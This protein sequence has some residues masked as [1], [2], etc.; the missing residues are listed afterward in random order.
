[1]TLRTFLKRADVQ[2]LYRDTFPSMPDQPP[3]PPMAAVSQTTR[4]SAVGTAFDY[5]LRFYVRHLN[6]DAVVCR[7]IAESGVRFAR[8]TIDDKAT[9]ARLESIIRTAKAA[10][11]AIQEHGVIRPE[12]AAAALALAPLDAIFRTKRFSPTWLVEPAAADI[13]DLLTLAELL[14]HQDWLVASRVCR[15]NC[16]FGEASLAIG[17][18]DCDLI[19]DGL[20]VDIKTT[21]EGRMRP[22]D[23]RQILAYWALSTMDPD[24]PAIDTVGVYGARHGV[25]T[26][27]PVAE[28]ASPAALQ[29][30]LTG[31]GGLMATGATQAVAPRV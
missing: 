10:E 8:V 7:W 11:A 18:A 6:P 26:S 20:L 12:H 23:L 17:G 16:T 14:H 4:A 15:L 29:A 19:V 30:F 9:N 27:I 2:Q 25:L 5:L 13:D 31:F 24:C 22:A 28:L 3:M 1:M 21:V